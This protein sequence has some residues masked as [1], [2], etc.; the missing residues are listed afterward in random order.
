M[1]LIASN[2]D[3]AWQTRRLSLQTDTGRSEH[4]ACRSKRTRI[5]PNTAL[6]ASNRQGP[7]QTRFPPVFKFGKQFVILQVLLI[8]RDLVDLRDDKNS[9]RAF[10]GPA[11]GGPH[12]EAQFSSTLA[13]FGPLEKPYQKSCEKRCFKQGQANCARVNEGDSTNRA[14][15]RFWLPKGLS[16]TVDGG[17]AQTFREAILRAD[18]TKQNHGKCFT[19]QQGMN[20]INYNCRS[21]LDHGFFISHL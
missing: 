9:N 3:G 1:L 7:Y 11:R 13:F 19:E 8:V 20:E 2:G 16:V 4:D 18:N 17:F 21:C 15:K 14:K 5:V 6:V 10:F 12:L